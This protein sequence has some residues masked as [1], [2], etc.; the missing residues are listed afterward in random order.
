MIPG[1]R[2]VSTTPCL[3]N[4]S[5]GWAD[6]SRGAS[7]RPWACPGGGGHKQNALLHRAEYLSRHQSQKERL[8]AEALRQRSAAVAEWRKFWRSMHVPHADVPHALPRLLN[9]LYVGKGAAAG[10]APQA[11]RTGGPG[12][13]GTPIKGFFLSFAR[14]ATPPAN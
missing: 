2:C 3:R 14:A 5:A 7:L 10:A 13:G 12:T 4:L 1:G 9:I 11:H 6:D 8:D